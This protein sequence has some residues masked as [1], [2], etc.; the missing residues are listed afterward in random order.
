MIDTRPAP[1][2]TPGT[3]IGELDTPCLLLDLDRFERNAGRVMGHLRDNGVGWRPH[4]KAHKSPILAR[5]Q[6]AIGALGVTCAKVSEAEVMVDGGIPSILVAN[7]LA[8]PAKYRRLAELQERARVI[9]CADAPDH[10]AMASAAGRSI[11]VEVPLLVEL[12]IGMDRVGVAPGQPALDLARRI[13]DTPGVRFAGIMG[14]E[15]HTLEVWPAEAKEA[16]IRGSVGLLV[17]TA[18][19]IEDAG[20]TVPIVSAG[21][22]GSYRTAA[23]VTGVTEL[24]AGGACYM[25]RFY[26]EECHLDGL[27]FALTIAASVTSRPAPDRAIIDAGFKTLSEQDELKPL[28]L[29]EPGIS[30]NHLSAEHGSLHL[31]PDAR[32][33]R[34]GD[35]VTLLPDYSDTTTFRHDAFIGHRG[36]VVD[37]VIPLAARGRLT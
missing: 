24:Q 28:V 35:R 37:Q 21:G 6:L 36:G 10:V 11:G 32:Q 26:A 8:L 15:G 12:N 18:R 23:G 14:Y 31:G 22:S 17:D 16:A 19:L 1:E 2:I 33:L 20:I 5:M 30:V 4:S 7:E 3:P 27:E 34:I 13:V 25:D 9:A 29:D